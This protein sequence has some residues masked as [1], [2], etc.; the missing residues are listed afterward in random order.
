[1]GLWGVAAHWVRGSSIRTTFFGFFRGRRDVIAFVC[2]W[3]PDFYRRGLLLVLR[4][5]LAVLYAGRIAI[6]AMLLPVIL[7]FRARGRC[8]ESFRAQMTSAWRL[9]SVK[10]SA[11]GR[12]RRFA[13]SIEKQ[14]E[15]QGVG[16]EL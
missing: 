6:A 2:R 12:Y 16:C 7:L 4:L 11:L 5:Q 15:E 9:A 1:M 10:L 8:F 14:S 3:R 13:S